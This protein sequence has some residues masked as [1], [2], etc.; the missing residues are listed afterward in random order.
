MA[1]CLSASELAQSAASRIWCDEAVKDWATPIAALGVRPGHFSERDYYAVPADN[2]Q[3]YPVYH[4]DRE[5][6]MRNTH[7]GRKHVDGLQSG[8]K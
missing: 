4:P 8:R 5:R 2:Y 6:R 1:L 7:Q 3:T